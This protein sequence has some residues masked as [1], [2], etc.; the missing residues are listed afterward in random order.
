MAA[1]NNP[2]Y[3]EPANAMQALMSGYQGYDRSQKAAK[4]S[5]LQAG[6]RDAMAAL[7]AGGDIR[8]PLAKLIGIGDVEGAKAIGEYANQ[9]ATQQYHQQSLAESGRHNRAQEG[10][11]ARE[12]GIKES[13][14]KIVPYGAGIMDRTGKMMHAPATDALLD[15]ETIADMAKQYRAGDTSVLTNLGRGAQGA[16]NIVKLRREVTR[17]NQEIGLGGSDQAMQ[18][19]QYAGDK[20]GLRANSTRTA[21]VEY[22]ANTANRAID[23]AN[24][25]MDKVPR[26]QFVPVNR[27]IA[28]WQSN[29][30]SPEQVAAATAVNT[31]ANEYARVVS[32]TGVPT[33]GSRNKA[34]ALLNS[35][36]SHEQFKAVTAMM[37]REI[38]SAK[39]AAGDTRQELRDTMS[40]RKGDHNNEPSKPKV[41][42]P[43][44]GF[45][46]Q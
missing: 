17:Q 23:I 14:P 24:E 43:P 4:E 15:P 12:L 40:G 5:E 44:P 29:T 19:A 9:S 46:I 32:P 1:S 18:N 8:S 3:V 6:R 16:E 20:A 27:L 31:L 10:I 34:S 11:S 21:A 13:E 45:V 25:A 37:R 2:F 42:P 38:M 39:G 22:A 7:Q 33:E 28:M 41:P 36:Q 35:A 30:G 26:T